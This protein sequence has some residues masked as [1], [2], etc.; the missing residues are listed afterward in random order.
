MTIGTTRENENELTHQIHKFLEDLE[1]VVWT[2]G[3]E[4]GN[5]D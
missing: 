1:S 2:R 4:G 5:I 3:N